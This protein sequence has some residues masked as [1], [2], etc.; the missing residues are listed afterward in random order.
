M[1]NFKKIVSIMEKEAKKRKAPVF[2]FENSIRETPFKTLISV[3]LSSRTKDEKTLSASKKLFSKVTTPKQ[4]LLLKNSEIEKAIYGVGFYKTKARNIKELSKI[5]I[6]KFKGKVPD[7]MEKLLVLPGVGRKTANLVLSISFGKNTIGVDTHVHRISNR[8]G[9]VKTKKP[10][11]TEKQLLKIIPNNLIKKLNKTLVAYG[12][13]ICTPMNPKCNICK[14]SSI[15]PKINVK[16]I[17][18]L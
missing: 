10:E 13:T 16:T 6:K 1:K 3:L 14:L 12:Q 11:E 2:E 7:S 18:L 9:W 17:N 4:M 8:L 5:L 15:C